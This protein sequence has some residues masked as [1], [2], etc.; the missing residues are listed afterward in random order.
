M[1][2]P[3]TG[4]TMPSQLQQ[5]YM[6]VPMK[7]RLVA[8]TAFLR[9]VVSSK[10]NCAIVFCSNIATVDF[11]HKMFSKLMAPT[12]TGEAQRL[13]DTELLKIHGDLSLAAR[14]EVMARVQRAATI[15]SENTKGIVLLSTDVAA[16]GLDLPAVRWIIQYDPPTE[17]QEYVHR[18]GRTAR[19]GR[20]GDA[21]LFL[22]PDEVG[23][24][25]FL[26][27]RGLQLHEMPL[28]SVLAS[29]R[30]KSLPGV[31]EQSGAFVL[32]QLMFK[33]V[34]ASDALSEDANKVRDRAQR[35][36]RERKT[37]KN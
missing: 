2:V 36:W 6:V 19:L 3:S 25:E 27:Q 28:A 18:A 8:L 10:D 22:T 20:R 23:Y 32:K 9:L 15:P 26:A 11:L 12:P 17:P 1:A 14:Q 21:L 34:A 5:H 33:I 16:R 37:A 31:K 29:L 4:L 7:E 35:G 24:V 13:L 30:F